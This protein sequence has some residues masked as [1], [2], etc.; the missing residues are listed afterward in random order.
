MFRTQRRCFCPATDNEIAVDAAGAVT[1]QRNRSGAT[2][3]DPPTIDDVFA[4]IEGAITADADE[5]IV[6]FDRDLGFPVDLTID[7]DDAVA[8]DEQGRRVE[9]LVLRT[10]A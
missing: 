5:I 9:W 8:D 1:G 3:P 6:S 10:P 4:A 2:E 7:F